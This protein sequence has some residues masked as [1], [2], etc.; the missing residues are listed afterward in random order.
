MLAA[1]IGLGDDAAW[2]SFATGVGPGRHGRFY[3][4]RWEG[5][6]LVQHRRDPWLPPPF[7]ERLADRGLTV[8]AIDVPKAPLGRV[9]EG[10]AVA[11]WM[12]HGPDGPIVQ[13]SPASPSHE[14]RR[15]FP[16]PP[17]FQC[18]AHHRTEAET[19][20]YERQLIERAQLRCRS[21]TEL[22]TSRQWDLF[23][24]VFAETHCV[25]HQCW[26]ELDRSHPRHPRAGG[27]DGSNTVRRIY[28]A[29]DDHLATLVEAAGPG[30]SVMVFALL[31]MGP[32]YSGT[33][34]VP[35]VLTRFEGPRRSPLV[36]AKRTVSWLKRHSRS[37]QG[38]MP[39]LV[40]RIGTAIEQ[41]PLPS[42][43][44]SVIPA[45]LPT[46]LIRYHGTTTDGD[47]G[48]S[49]PEACLALRHELL[50]LVDPATGN[51]LVRDVVMTREAFDGPHAAALADLIVLWAAQ[52]PVRAAHSPRFG[53]IAIDPPDQRSGNHRAGG[54]LIS[55]PS[56]SHARVATR[57]PTPVTDMATTIATHLGV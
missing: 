27:G 3:H 5:R 19:S 43:P 6:S 49:T 17:P 11:D 40:T 32:N 20:A 7:W 50:R 56:A 29:V 51:P 26:H 13:W 1:P 57:R 39:R 41:R 54:W 8:A 28:R 38:S 18:D 10:L 30:A 44:F 2:M 46:T 45:D 12:P 35:E 25:G 31:G 42:P 22:L 55:S 24:G 16:T 33:H 15:H 4:H 14:L 48:R 47:V 52:A 21:M 34:L 9:G 23:L 37:L 36:A 53:T